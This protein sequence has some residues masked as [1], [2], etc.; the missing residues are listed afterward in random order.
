MHKTLGPRN[1]CHRDISDFRFGQNAFFKLFLAQVEFL[2]ETQEKTIIWDGR[3]YHRKSLDK[4]CGDVLGI[5]YYKKITTDVM[6]VTFVPLNSLLKE[7]EIFKYLD[8]DLSI[9]QVFG[10][11]RAISS[12]PGE[13]LVLVIKKRCYNYPRF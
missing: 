10:V 2:A 8:G 13:Y 5:N 6:G 1:F 7:M 12:D 4:L 11:I 3:L 9:P